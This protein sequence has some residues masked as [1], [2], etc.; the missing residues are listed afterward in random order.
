MLGDRVHEWLIALCDPQGTGELPARRLE[1]AGFA[2]L[3]TLAA[4]HGVAP[5]VCRNLDRLISAAGWESLLSNH[6]VAEKRELAATAL[7]AAKREWLQFIATTLHLRQAAERLLAHL[8]QHSLPAAVVKGED[9]ADRLYPQPALRPFR[10]IDLL[11]PREAF[12]LSAPHME[13]LGHVRVASGE[14]HD[15]GYGEQTWD[16][17]SL[18]RVR[19]DMHWNLINSPSQRRASSLAF[20]DVN[21][22]QCPR[23]GRLRASAG[24]MLLIATVHA[25]LG[26]RF[27]RLQHLC[28]IRQICRGAAG[29]LDPT[30][31]AETALRCGV[32]ASLC[33][34]LAVTANLLHDPH[35][36]ALLAEL[37]LPRHR[38]RWKLLV[39]RGTLLEPY[40]GPHKLRRTL[41]R[42]WMKR[43]G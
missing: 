18:P 41:V 26:H 9:F 42:E 16:S 5:A 3:L 43:A 17:I 8:A 24:S 4:E 23:T 22:A 34:G 27:D 7:A 14:R 20:D 13:A 33:G 39:D 21:W 29:A 19:V 31:L 11:L 6:E 12:E 36:E 37:R 2:R 10:D 30:E 40:T 1:L 38:T 28:D 35:C 15:S 25:V 32:A